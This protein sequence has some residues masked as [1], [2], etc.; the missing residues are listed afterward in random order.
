[1]LMRDVAS[2]EEQKISKSRCWRCDILLAMDERCRVEC[3]RCCFHYG[4]VLLLFC[5]RACIVHSIATTV[6]AQSKA[7]VL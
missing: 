2:M 5:C 1:M 6:V 4:C 3:C 7:N